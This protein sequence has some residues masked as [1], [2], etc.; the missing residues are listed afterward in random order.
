MQVNQS[1]HQ[2]SLNPLDTNHTHNSWDGVILQLET[3]PHCQF[4][5]HAALNRP[6]CREC[7]LIAGAMRAGS[8]R[9]RFV[10]GVVPKMEMRG[11]CRV[12]TMQQLHHDWI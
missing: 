2:K 8:R 12:S 1:G 3:E 5:Q 6:P 10:S 7:Q 11:F 9:K 4:R